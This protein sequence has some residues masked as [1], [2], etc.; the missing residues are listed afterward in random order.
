MPHMAIYDMTGEKAGEIEV[1]DDLL[2]LPFN[3]DLVHQAVVAADYGRKR[4][5]GKAKRRGEVS[6]TGAKW[7]RQKGLGRARHGDRGAPIFVGGGAAHGPTGVAAGHRMPRKMRRKATFTALSERAREGAVTIV[8]NVRLEA[9]STRRFVQVLEDLELEGRILMLVGEQE[10]ADRALQL[11][12]RNV[13][14]LVMR[15]MPHFNARDV[16]WA[17]TIVITRA[18]LE[19]LIGGGADDAN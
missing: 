14:G 7:Y 4:R 15:P 19:Q 12:A 9:I 2:G 10:A 16:L 11:S 5:C 6:L 18:G 13:P 17:E 8:D 1:P 3:P